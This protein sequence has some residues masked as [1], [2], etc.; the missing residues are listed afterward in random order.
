[1][2]GTQLSYWF[3]PPAPS[4]LG[5]GPAIAMVL[6]TNPLGGAGARVPPASIMNTVTGS[7]ASGGLGESK[8]EFFLHNFRRYALYCGSRHTFGPSA[9]V[10]P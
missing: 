8:L 5:G 6:S 10:W 2:D 9:P 4:A 7:V 1:V 3:N